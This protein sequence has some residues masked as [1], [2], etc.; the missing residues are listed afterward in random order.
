MNKT[1][2]NDPRLSFKAKGVL[3][4]LL[5]KPD[6]WIVYVNHLSKQ[7]TDGKHAVRS[8]LNELIDC[9]YAVFERERNDNGEYISGSYTIYETPRSSF[10]HVDNPNVD[11]RTLLSNDSLLCNEGS[12]EN[13]SDEPL[14]P[15][16]E[17]TFD[18]PDT[19]STVEDV[20]E[21]PAPV[22]QQQ[23]NKNHLKYELVSNFVEVSNIPHPDATTPKKAK[24]V[25]A[26]WW[27]PLL[28]MSEWC[29]WDADL[30][31]RLMRKT[32]RKMTGD[33]LTIS[34]PKSILNVAKSLFAE[35]LRKKAE[36]ER[37][38]AKMEADPQYQLGRKLNQLEQ[39]DAEDRAERN[40]E[41][42]KAH[43]ERVSAFMGK[44]KQNSPV[45]SFD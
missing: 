4:Y 14:A 31:T 6:D 7:S 3:A 38:I 1:G 12:K 36:H 17:Q 24:A 27:T 15:A 19:S 21:E 32:V 34:N 33:R 22:E 37:A 2:L 39:A 45:N 13:G 11:N 10:P 25:N 44:V 43:R 8:A 30:T 29:E 28:E 26:L 16:V 23:V 9:G 42:Y 20:A 18:D 5:S 35:H 40:R 41:K